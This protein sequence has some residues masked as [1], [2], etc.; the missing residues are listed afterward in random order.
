MASQRLRPAARPGSRHLHFACA[1]CVPP[2][3]PNTHLSPCT[4]SLWTPRPS[5]PPAVRAPPG[6]RLHTALP[7]VCVCA[8]LAD[9]GA[10][11]ATCPCMRA[12]T[13]HS[14]LATACPLAACAA[15][16]RPPWRR[17]LEQRHLLA[18]NV[19][20]RRASAPRRRSAGE[21]LGQP[22]AA[23]GLQ[24]VSAPPASSSAWR[25]RA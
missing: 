21:V 8:C 9:S 2:R 10:C 19:I 25:R 11:I 17:L 24:Q 23:V 14:V 1:F 5:M 6:N 18:A 7:D 22:R 13:A 4:D 16:T 3:R 12:R 15:Q 20:N